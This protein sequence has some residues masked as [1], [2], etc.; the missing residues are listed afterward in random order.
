VAQARQR[1]GQ[2]W[3]LHGA[4]TNADI[5]A[6]V[7]T[8]DEFRLPRTVTTPLD[9]ALSSGTVTG[10][11]ATRTLRVAWTLADMDGLE[12]PSVDQIAEALEFRDRRPT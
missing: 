7:L 10:T 5:A 11:G 12:R 2:R 4:R 1:A 3:A 9:D 6:T 8:R